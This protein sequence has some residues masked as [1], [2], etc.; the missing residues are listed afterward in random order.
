MTYV[1][2]CVSF[3]GGLYS[4]DIGY[5]GT[6]C[7]KC[8]NGSFVA[9]NKAPGTQIQDCKSCPLGEEATWRDYLTSI[10]KMVISQLVI[11]V[12]CCLF[13]KKTFEMKAMKQCFP[14]LFSYRSFMYF[15]VPIIHAFAVNIG[16]MGLGQGEVGWYDLLLTSSS[17]IVRDLGFP[18]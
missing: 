17:P 14:F 11:S 7:K 2:L 13:K 15:T 1:L 18:W 9:Y 16:P 12:S 5:V 6:S 10:L 8:P 4:D 3:L